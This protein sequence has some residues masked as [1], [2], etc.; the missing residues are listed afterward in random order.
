MKRAEGDTSAGTQNKEP[1]ESVSC[2]DVNDD[3]LASVAQDLLA[4]HGTKHVKEHTTSDGPTAKVGLSEDEWKLCRRFSE[5]D[6]LGAKRLVVRGVGAG[7]VLRDQRQRT[8][9][10]MLMLT[11][12]SGTALKCEILR[13]LLHH[14]YSGCINQQDLQGCTALMYACRQ[15]TAPVVEVMLQHGASV[16]CAD[17]TGMTPLM[18]AAVADSTDVMDVLCAAT[19]KSPSASET[20]NW[21]DVG[22][23]TALHWC[24][25]LGNLACFQ[26]LVA[27]PRVNLLAVDDHG[28][29]VLHHL[30]RLIDSPCVEMTQWLTQSVPPESLMRLALMECIDNDASTGQTAEELASALKNASFLA[31]FNPALTQAREKHAAA[32]HHR[33]GP[34][35]V[36][37]V[38]AADDADSAEYHRAYNRV[39]DA[40][41]REKK[42]NLEETVRELS[43]R[44]EKLF[45]LLDM[46]RKEA[47]DLRST[48]CTSDSCWFAVTDEDQQTH[49]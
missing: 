4:Q 1:N 6:L 36:R 45:G 39:Y 43:R 12:A 25:V 18:F 37:P 40:K 27:Q 44:S 3:F 13:L 42:E 38:F 22:G 49:A 26:R 33:Q 35:H 19:N 7:G 28:A 15:G 11:I 9:L 2:C 47:A 29:A 48:L 31:V 21:R 8:P 24:A 5:D 10:H 41:K 20:Y 46:A 30:A 34:C 17:V 16:E 23:K 32:P 14:G